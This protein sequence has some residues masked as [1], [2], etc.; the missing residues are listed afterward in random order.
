MQITSLEKVF[1]PTDSNA[2]ETKW[3]HSFEVADITKHLNKCY[4]T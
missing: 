1:I 2:K 3:S 4:E